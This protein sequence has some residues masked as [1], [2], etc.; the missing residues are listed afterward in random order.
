MAL[1]AQELFN[2]HKLVV[3]MF[4]AAPG[5]IYLPNISTFFEANG[6]SLDSLTDM[7]GQTDF[8]TKLYPSSQTNA[9]FASQLL[10]TYSLQSNP[11]AL[12]F[13]ASLQASGLN[14]G[15]IALR[16]G[17]TINSTTSTDPALLAAKAILENKAI[18]SSIYSGIP[19]GIGGG[20]A[21]DLPT[22][23]SVLRDV[24]ADP[25]SI[26]PP[27]VTPPPVVI[28][29]PPVV[30]APITT[31]TLAA[32]TDTLVGT[33]LNE[34]YNATSTTLTAVDNINGA[35]GID[36][37]N[38]THTPNAAFPAVAITNVE[39]FN[40]Q[41]NNTL[42]SSDLSGFTGLTNFNADR[43][44]N[45][46]IT[47]TNAAA[48]VQYGLIGDGSSRV[49]TG[50]NFGYAPAATTATLNLTGGVKSA[51]ANNVVITGTGVTATVINSS[52]AANSLS[53]ASVSGSITTPAT[54]L[55]TTINATSNLTTALST[56]A[57]TQLTITGNSTVDLRGI[58]YGSALNNTLATIDA[59]AQTAGGTLIRAGNSTTL[60]FT[61]GAG[62][63]T[64][65]LGSVLTA[66]ASVDGGGGVDTLRT[67]DATYVSA[68]TGA[69]IKNFEILDVSGG[70]TVDLA[71]LAANN[72]LTGLRLGAGTNVLNN[73]SAALANNVT[74]YA[75]GSPTLNLA[76]GA[77]TV[78]LEFNDPAHPNLTDLS[79][80]GVTSLNI[81]ATS[82]LTIT[83][84]TNLAT[85]TTV[86]V[87]GAGQAVF[88]PNA[89]PLNAGFVLDASAA[90]G[91]VQFSAGITNTNGFTYKGS[92]G[93]NSVVIGAAPAT[94]DLA[95]S[96]AKADSVTPNS[97]TG[98]SDTVFHVVS[99]FTN[100][101]TTG[102]RLQFAT[103]I[104]ITP[105]AAA[106]TATGVANLTAQVSTGIITF[107]GPA[108]P[109]A[110][111]QTKIAAAA[112]LA[113]V[114]AN[115]NANGK[116]EIAFEDGGNT[117]VFY[118]ADNVATFTAGTDFIIQ[119]TGLTGVTALSKTGSAA[120]TIY[121]G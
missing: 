109:G 38:Y 119:L 58:N 52:G 71:N 29:A 78:T 97:A 83:N 65:S 39:I 94:I 105:D 4:N 102:D 82:G 79:L 60:K 35:G 47:T 40:L 112:F 76:G 50:L 18:L 21:T 106:G 103:L 80:P 91:T 90:T 63:D 104:T 5:A 81:K 19:G 9:Q 23:Q 11:E 98:T 51:I 121:A 88:N 62:N 17:I 89:A 95:R 48:G 8:F 118:Q 37:L 22:L 66:G 10:T 56:T 74:V 12:A 13:V 36:T 14:K 31:F 115:P 34:T 96:V 120:N 43:V 41:T 32:G 28:I 30:V 75:S 53:T 77:T 114:N 59:S 117:Y 33:G 2:V 107:G 113:G 108:A 101:A 42:Q 24:T 6:R 15:Q 25:S 85:L 69:F 110:T 87:T 111:L 54:S 86:T 45:G 7:L 20:S 26:Y 1:S 92:S 46:A 61:G 84:F 70:I 44:V 100:A 99:G 64:V 49:I 3:A 16:V 55:A 27:V 72:T 57:D 93:F 68:V 116:N 67:T 73:V